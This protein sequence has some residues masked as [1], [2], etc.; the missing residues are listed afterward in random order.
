MTTRRKSC[1]LDPAF[2]EGAEPGAG[3]VVVHRAIGKMRLARPRTRHTHALVT[4]RRPLVHHQMR[5]V[6]MKLQCVA[7]AVTEGLHLEHIA[8]G[9]KLGA[10]GKIKTFAVPLVDLLRPRIDHGQSGCGRPDRVV[11]D[12]HL[13]FR[14]REYMAAERTRTHLRAEAN[15]EERLLLFQRHGDPVDLAP[16]EVVGVVGAHRAAE[17]DGAGMLGKRRRQRLLEPRPAHVERKAELAERLA[18]AAGCGMLLV[19]NDQDW[20][21]HCSQGIGARSCGIAFARK[22]KMAGDQAAAARVAGGAYDRP[23]SSLV[24]PASA[25]SPAMRRRRSMRSRCDTPSRSAARHRRLSSSSSRLP[26]A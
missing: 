7:S 24:S 23:Y 15:A 8:F 4:A 20:L 6:G 25:V 26:S 21:W 5:H 18:D 3:A 12:L 17:N 14:V 1:A 22:F 13:A 2:E 16:D 10:G 11:A 19:E 9:Q